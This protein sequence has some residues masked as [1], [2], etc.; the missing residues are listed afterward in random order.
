MVFL[1]NFPLN[2][3]IFPDAWALGISTVLTVVIQLGL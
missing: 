3:H 1:L 2:Q